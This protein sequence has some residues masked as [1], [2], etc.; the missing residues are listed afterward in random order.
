VTRI[1]EAPSYAPSAEAV[2]AGAG[3]ENFPVASRALPRRERSHLLAI[4][5]FARLVDE[6][7]DAEPDDAAAGPQPGD[8]AVDAE[9]GADRAQQRLAALAWLEGELD[10]ALRGEAEHPLLVRLG[11]SARACRLTREPFVRLIEANRQDQRVSSYE[12]WEQLRGYC[13]LSADP[14]GELVL[15]VLGLATPERIALSDSICTALQLTEHCQDVAEDLA[16]GRV[17]LPAEDLR[18]FGC[19]QA[20]LAAAHAGGPLRQVIAFEVA[21]ARSLFDEG[22]PLVAELQ[23]RRRLAVAAFVAGGRAALEAIER[24]GYDVLVGPPHAGR[25]RRAVA[26]ARTLLAAGLAGS[27]R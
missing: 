22:T 7:G 14:V 25:T 13:S 24:A 16:R 23:G 15:G 6:L 18:R 21:R 12:T 20:E 5:G 9:G 27:G 11:E 19:E 1:A 17:Y 3:G 4:Y 26:L 2:M 10:R 8:G